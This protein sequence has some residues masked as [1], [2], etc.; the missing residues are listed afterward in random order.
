MLQ[1]CKI[2][3]GLAVSVTGKQK[4]FGK[5][6]SAAVKAVP[7]IENAI[8]T[9][10]E[11]K[12]RGGSALDMLHNAVGESMVAAQ[13]KKL[14]SEIRSQQRRIL[15]VED[16]CDIMEAEAVT[17]SELGMII[18]GYLG[19]RK[20]KGRNKAENDIHKDDESDVKSLMNQIKFLQNVVQENARQQQNDEK[21]RKAAIAA[22]EKKIISGSTKKKK[23]QS[24]GSTDIKPVENAL[25]QDCVEKTNKLTKRLGELGAEIK[26]IKTSV[27]H[28][29]TD[30]S[31]KEST[32][33]VVE[34]K[35]ANDNDSATKKELEYFRNSPIH[36]SGTV[37]MYSETTPSRQRRTPSPLALNQNSKDVHEGLNTP[38]FTDWDGNSLDMKQKISQSNHN[39]PH[40]LTNSSR[41]RVL[42][43]VNGTRPNS[44]FNA[45]NKYLKKEMA[46]SMRLLRCQADE[47][48]QVK[49]IIRGM[50]KD[51]ENV[52]LKM[53]TKALNVLERSINS[54]LD[55]SAPS[56]GR[57]CMPAEGGSEAMA[58]IKYELGILRQSILLLL[59]PEVS[60]ILCACHSDH[61]VQSQ[62]LD[63]LRGQV[64]SL[65]G[66]LRREQQCRRQET[67]DA[68]APGAL[69]CHR[70]PV[71][72]VA[73]IS[74]P[75]FVRQV[76]SR[77]N[78][79]KS[80]QS[81]ANV[82]TEHPSR[83]STSHSTIVNATIGE[84]EKR[85]IG[86]ILSEGKRISPT[87]IVGA[88]SSSPRLKFNNSITKYPFVN[89][90]GH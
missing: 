5:L 69:T 88:L 45:E 19:G 10:L 57:V 37:V 85:M 76:Q 50:R 41:D 42:G 55:K 31:W 84:K 53:T 82:L 75:C 4:L 44:S 2:S 28:L 77:L 56:S 61:I 3:S 87:P 30:K 81:L 60:P 24:D 48:V 73:S 63:R 70:T 89:L 47:I 43:I 86:A 26:M 66:E 16:K 23:K 11:K 12:R 79:V 14:Q 1:P 25:L 36:N 65:E 49:G 83:A 51:L 80:L 34:S 54:A 9:K 27:A 35:L 64:K 72:M 8:E 32:S 7:K 90:S 17:K 15:Y 38:S 18:E 33:E 78:S 67:I 39:E 52:K 6:K 29:S 74:G 20:R 62:E 68:T 71:H 13:V 58:A 22:L 21:E 59:S 46:N 40:H